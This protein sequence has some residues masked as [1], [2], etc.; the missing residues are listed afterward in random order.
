VAIFEEYCYLYNGKSIA[1][2]VGKC[3]NALGETVYYAKSKYKRIYSIAECPDKALE[4]CV[5]KIKFSIS[6]SQKQISLLK[7]DKATALAKSFFERN[8]SDKCLV[9][10]LKEKLSY[11]VCVEDE[12]LTFQA[13]LSTSNIDSPIDEQM[14]P[15]TVIAIIYV[16]LITGECDMVE[17]K[18]KIQD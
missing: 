1:I 13:T 12:I 18:G 15:L 8:Y 9:K 14:K 5:R 17:T 11:N 6:L 2:K 3:D 4:K 16:N 7:Q 10:E